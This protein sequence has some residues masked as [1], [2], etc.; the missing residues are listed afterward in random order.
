MRHICFDYKT[1]VTPCFVFPYSSQK[2]ADFVPQLS[3][4][5]IIA[6]IPVPDTPLINSSIALA[7]AN[8]PDNG[9]NHVM[10]AW[11]NGQAIINK[12]PA[13]NRSGIDEEAFGV[14]TILHDLGW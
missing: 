12:L 4:T 1:S 5:R 2:Q 14:A 3:V 7:R 6:G 11:L 13:V 9:F 10:R 8:L